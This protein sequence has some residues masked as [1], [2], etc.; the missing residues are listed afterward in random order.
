MF[1]TR[2][3]KQRQIATNEEAVVLR[4]IALSVA[5]PD[6]KF[7]EV[8]SWCGDSAVIFGKVAQ[9]NGGHLYCVDWWKG[10]VGTELAEIAAKEDVFSLFWRRMCHEGLE[11]VVIPIRGRSGDAASV[12]RAD[13]FDLVFID[14]DHRYEYILEDI[15]NYLPVVRKKGIICGHDCEGRI[16][17]YEESFLERG[18]NVD[19]YE[20]VHCGV[21]LAVGTVF[22]RYSIDHSV[23]SVRS[24]AQNGDWERTNLLFPEIKNSRQS[25]PPLMAHTSIYHIQRYGRFVYG[26]PRTLCDL[27]IR[28]ET[29]RNDPDVIK[30]TSLE[31]LLEQINEPL[32]SDNL[33]LLIEEYRGFNLVRY[34]DQVFG[35]S[36]ALGALDINAIDKDAFINYQSVGKAVLGNSIDD[37]KRGVDRVLSQTSMFVKG[38]EWGRQKLRGVF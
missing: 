35:L 4:T 27:D 20:T 26:I 1:G 10:N 13:C 17:D 5:R 14:G 15:K 11:D 3:L 36:Q 25:N 34:N 19:Y 30:A 29:T 18:K 6:C 9:E 28:D 37:A 2:D 7:L 23:W 12:F 33:P 16:D 24:G 38:V 21:V 31:K 22:D 32:S 8:G